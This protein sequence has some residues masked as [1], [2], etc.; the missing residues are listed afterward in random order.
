M[1]THQ[2]TTTVAVL[3]AGPMGQALAGALL[4]RGHDVVVWNRTATRLEPVVARG[5][6]PATTPAEA[7]AQATLTLVNVID[8]A[9]ATAIVDQ[10]GEAASGRTIIGLASDTPDSSRELQSRAT[11]LGARYLGGAIMTPVATIGTEHGSIL[12]DGSEDVVERHRTVLEGLGAISWVG[13][14]PGTAAG[15]DMA[16]LD[17][18]W[19]SIGGYLHGAEVARKAGI[20]AASLLPHALGIV[21]ILT[22][23]VTDLA[24]R[25]DQGTHDD[26]TSDLES[27]SASLDH[28][29]HA[30]H[31]AG[32][33]ADALE[34]L[35]RVT[36]RGVD[37]GHGKDE[38]TRVSFAEAAA[39]A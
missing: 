6:R 24:G 19:T 7:V 32:L 34:A 1:T 8:N 18:F 20:D 25:L 22:P 2:D 14:Q 26:A 35:R 11:A 31:D 38:I 37:A 27:I 12:L 10:V 30:A 36:R 5:A 16:L 3:G 29:V 23:I 28:L 9:A 39:L 17:F 4:D 33:G 13:E 15:Y 21:S